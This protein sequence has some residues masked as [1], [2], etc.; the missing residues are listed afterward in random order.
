MGVKITPWWTYM[1]IV[2]G[3]LE[4]LRVNRRPTAVP[5]VSTDRHEWCAD[6]CS[7]CADRRR[8]LLL[9]SGVPTV[10]GLAGGGFCRVPTTPALCCCVCQCMASALFPPVLILHHLVALTKVDLEPIPPVELVREEEDKV[11]E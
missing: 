4:V 6:R 2:G 7:G 9:N 5:V 8:R 3:P 10:L 11:G 1:R